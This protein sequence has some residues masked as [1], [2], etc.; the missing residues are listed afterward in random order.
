MIT[1][2]RRLISEEDAT[3]K[4]LVLAR[5][6]HIPDGCYD[7]P[8][9]DRMSDFDAQKWLSLCDL[10]KAAQRRNPD[11]SSA[12]AVPYTLRSIYGMKA[13]FTVVLENSPDTLVELAA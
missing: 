4:L 11:P 13:P 3:A 9:A 5:R 7:E 2:T 10:L 1:V 8:V 6:Y 12:C